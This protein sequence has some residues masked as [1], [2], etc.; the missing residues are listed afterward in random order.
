MAIFCAMPSDRLDR[1]RVVGLNI[2]SKVGP[3][4]LALSRPSLPKAKLN[5][6][7]SRAQNLSPPSDTMT[8]VLVP[9]HTLTM[10]GD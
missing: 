3:E 9:M 5:A 8:I 7:L 1:L 2:F 6:D 4:Y 10:E